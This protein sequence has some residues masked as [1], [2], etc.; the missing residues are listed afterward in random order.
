MQQAVRS[1]DAFVRRLLRWGR[2]NRRAFPWREESDPFRLLVTEVLV[3]RSRSGTVAKVYEQLFDRWPD[4]EALAAAS[5][6]DI[7]EVIAPLGLTG[8]ARTL[9]RMA[10][11][12]VERG[13]VPRSVEQMLRL[14]GVGRYAATAT[15]ASAFNRRAV[16]VDGTSAR[17]YR[18]VFGLQRLGPD[19]VDD[20]LWA[21]VERVAP[22]RGLAEWNWAVLDL[23][24]AICLPKVPR[25]EE[26]PVRPACWYG[27][28]D[29]SASDPALPP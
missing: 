14:S 15:A 26:C 12:V 2:A 9:K 19:K 8:R 17:V 20:E 21:I 25:C 7:R 3:Q 22:K 16:S 29:L 13:G 24:A 1:R 10:Q 11:E 6:E 27:S 23:A 4:A 28:A 18:R 5:E